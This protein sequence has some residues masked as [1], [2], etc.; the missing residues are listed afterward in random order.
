[1]LVSD[2]LRPEDRATGSPY[3]TFLAKQFPRTVLITATATNTAGSPSGTSALDIPEI[4]IT[5]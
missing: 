4:V 2:Q 1:M 5:P 3:V